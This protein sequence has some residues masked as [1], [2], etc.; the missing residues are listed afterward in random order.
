MYDYK[1]FFNFYLKKKTNNSYCWFSSDDPSLEYMK[2]SGP[3][4][5]RQNTW[6][7]Q[8]INYITDTTVKR[9]VWVPFLVKR[10]WR[11]SVK[12]NRNGLAC[13]CS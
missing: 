4:I 10:K 13:K 5:Y 1:I 12:E 9:H 7:F 3:T 11:L 8:H 2:K 6:K